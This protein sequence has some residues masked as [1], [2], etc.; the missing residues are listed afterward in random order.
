MRRLIAI[1]STVILVLAVSFPSKAANTAYV[2]AW[3]GLSYSGTTATCSLTVYAGYSTDSIEAT[4]KLMHGSTTVKQWTNLTAN[5]Y[6]LF[7]DTANVTHGETYTLQIT[8]KVNGVSYTVA[9]TTKTC[10]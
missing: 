6:L 9:D 5:G 7:S 2:S 10:P 1:L 8:L 3:P 4:V